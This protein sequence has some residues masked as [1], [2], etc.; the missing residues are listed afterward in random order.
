MKILRLVLLGVGLVI[1]VAGGAAGV[2]YYRFQ[3]FVRTPFGAPGERIVEIPAGATLS[4]VSRTLE[5]AGAV[6]DGWRFYLYGRIEGAERKLKRGEYGLALPATPTALLAQLLSGKVKTYKV[7]VPEGLRMDEIAPLFGEAGVADPRALLAAMR[8]PALMKRLAVPNPTAEGFL[9]P[10]TYLEPKGR[11]PASIVAELVQHFKAAY[12]R[13]RAVPGASKLTLLQAVT[14]ASIVEKET[15]AAEERPRISCVFHNR[16][17]LG[18]KLQTD[19]TVIYAVLLAEGHFD[20]NLTKAMLL[21]PHPYNTYSVHGLP[22][23]PIAN[24]GYAA[25]FAA[26]HPIACRDLYFVAKGN[27][28]HAFCPT[29]ECHNQNVQHF[30]IEPS[31]RGRR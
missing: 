11:K 17:R 5:A 18:M 31:Q 23:G 19:P 4:E 27:G 9:F 16:L 21:R 13:A 29:L 7:T 10:D 12:A 20:G 30:Q 1:L 14:L 25:L 28:T 8:D 15:G 26:L 2:W 3:H 24:P 22:P 6:S